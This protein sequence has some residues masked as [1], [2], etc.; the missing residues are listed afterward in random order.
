MKTQL[1][2]AVVLLGLLLG[3]STVNAQTKDNAVPMDPALRY[4]QLDN[5]LTYYIR[6]NAQPEDRAE[7]YLVVDAGAILENPDQNGLAHFCEHMAFN[8]T[9]NFEKHEIIE[10]LQSIGMKFGPEINAYTAHDNTTYMLQKVP[11]DVPGAVD[12]ALLILHDWAGKVAY[13][14][15]EIDNERGVIHEEWRVRRGADFRM[16]NKYQK[17]VFKDSKYAVHDVIGDID[18]IDNFDYQT[19]KDFYHDWYRPNLQAIIAVGDFNADD[20]EAKIKTLFGELKNPVN[21]RP[22]EEFEVPEHKETLVSVVKD[23]EATQT[24]SLVFYKHDPATVKDMNY[25]RESILQQLYSMMINQRLQEKL[26][27]K[28]PPFV[29]AFSAYI[30]YLR[31]VDAYLAGALANNNEALSALEAVL[32]ENQRVMQYGFV[33]SELER[34]KE[35][36]ISMIEKSYRE[37]DKKKSA[38]YM[39]QYQ[40]HFLD[41]E[42]VPGVEF[43]NDF[44]KDV[45]PTVTLDEMNSLAEKYIRKENRVV[46]VTGPEKEGVTMPSENE[47]LEVVEKVENMTVEPYEDKV[48]DAPLVANE[49]VPGK[50]AKKSK[51][52]QLGTETWIM[53]NGVKVVF[54]PTDF[55][56]DE[57]LLSAWSYGGTSA[58]KTDYLPSA[59]F[60]TDIVDESGLGKLD[61]NSLQKKLTGKIVRVSPYIGETYEGFYGSCSPKDYEVMLKLIYLYFTEPRLDGDAVESLMTRTRGMLENRSSRPQTAISDTMTMTLAQYHPRVEPFTAEYLD[62]ADPD[63]ALKIFKRRFGDPSGF[64]FYF[65]GNIDTKEARP[66]I[67]KWLGGLPTVTREENYTDHNIR[68]PKGDLQKVIEREMETPQGTVA[69]AF[70]GEYDYDVARDR[71]LLNAV[72][73]ILD[74]RYTETIR[75]DEGGTYGVMIRLAQDKYPYEHY[76]I[77]VMFNSDPERTDELK[78]IVY[79]EIEDLKENG[80][81]EKDLQGFKENKI[82]TR[83]ENLK[84]NR[85]WLS[86]LAAQDRQ[87]QNLSN[88]DGYED[89]IN[90][91]TAEEVQEAAKRFLSNGSK[92]FIMLPE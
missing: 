82:K 53:K 86:M 7:F 4:G 49:P 78:A 61:K 69:I 85:F 55:K 72:K 20:I 46:V 59:A 48:V 57:I 92:E 10:W 79:R 19:I 24:M 89:M 5:G 42:P 66:M 32:I 39:N 22:R 17:V 63:R 3:F 76:D 30:P 15:E 2:T 35:E 47:V 77:K 28:K 90:S 12:T 84:E 11:L 18:I 87:L 74:V 88:M 45:L 14:N 33:E 37:K 34:S 38:E 68:P 51:D 6:E 65:V 31:T 71:V 70:D 25:Y 23:K 80:P 36:M 64:T 16:M 62:R 52:K 13:E 67:E 1:I 54:K 83:R 56:D 44:V 26:T 21:E 58:V 43:D 73:D 40:S 29:Y 50:R 75:E 81:R 60:A 27:E 8:G 9:E 41:N 91:I